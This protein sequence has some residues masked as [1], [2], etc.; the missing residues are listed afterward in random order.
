MFIGS[1]T[2]LGGAVAVLA[3]ANLLNNWFAPTAYVLTAV[4]ACVLLLGLLRLAKGTWADAGLDQDTLR[5]G[6]AWGLALS[7]G[8]AIVV[9][10]GVL[11]PPTRHL[12]LDPRVEGAGPKAI[13]FAALVR[14][15]VGTVLLEEIGFRGVLYGLAARVRGF[16]WATAISSGLF[17]L[18]HLLPAISVVADHPAARGAGS[19]LGVAVAVTV[20][21]LATSLVGVGLC[22]LRRRSGSLVPCIALHWTVNALAYLAAYLAFQ[23]ST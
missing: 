3:V 14:V 16:T 23:T 9:L 7:V 19:P 4:I 17:G 15:P 8:A 2:A 6:V 13:A 12:F 22:E 5:Q 21:M 18:W 10:A 11:A 1:R 20:A